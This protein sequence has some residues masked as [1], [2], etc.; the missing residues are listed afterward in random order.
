MY[1]TK[2]AVYGYDDVNRLTISLNSS[3]PYAFFTFSSQFTVIPR[4]FFD[5]VGFVQEVYTGQE[6]VFK[7]VKSAAYTGWLHFSVDNGTG[8]TC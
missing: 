6:V 3:P 1:A 4:P 2:E 8:A 5:L 7:F